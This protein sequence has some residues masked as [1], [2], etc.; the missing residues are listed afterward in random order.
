MLYVLIGNITHTR[1][2]QLYKVCPGQIWPSL[3]DG[4][5]AIVTHFR[6]YSRVGKKARLV[7]IGAW[8]I[9]EQIKHVYVAGGV[10]TKARVLFLY[11]PPWVKGVTPMEKVIW[12]NNLERSIQQVFWGIKKSFVVGCPK[13]NYTSVLC[14]SKLKNIHWYISGWSFSIK[15]NSIWPSIAV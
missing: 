4:T 6:V 10:P 11:T 2:Q 13:M 3:L 12:L 1:Q 15:D 5:A 8:C 7:K 14:V 9:L